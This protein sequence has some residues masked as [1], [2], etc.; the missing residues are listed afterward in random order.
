MR[1]KLVRRLRRNGSIVAALVLAALGIGALGYHVLDGLPWLDGVLNAAMI[2]TGMGP[3][4]PVRSSAAKV[5][6]I[7][8]AIFSG[9][10]FLT[11][12]ALLLAP[13]V[14]HFLHHFHIELDE[15]ELTRPPVERPHDSE[16]PPPG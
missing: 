11:M 13:A 4:S 6:A 3:V 1:R 15:L 12:V 5:F 16:G 7:F 8:Y 14:S 10:F 9:I 2:L